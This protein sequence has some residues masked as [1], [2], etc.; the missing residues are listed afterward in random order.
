MEMATLVAVSSR[1]R[2]P[3]RRSSQPTRVSVDPRRSTR[4]QLASP[5]LSHSAPDGSK[6]PQLHIDQN[7]HLDSL[8]SAHQRDLVIVELN[9]PLLARHRCECSIRALGIVVT[10]EVRFSQQHFSEIPSPTPTKLTDHIDI[11]AGHDRHTLP[12]RFVAASERQLKLPFGRSSRAA[13]SACGRGSRLT[14]RCQ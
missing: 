1:P 7:R 6:G 13:C 9:V 14:A 11:L 2:W 8:I 5:P 3:V 4:L 10:T 12:G